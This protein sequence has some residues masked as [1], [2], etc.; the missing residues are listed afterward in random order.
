MI[1]MNEFL[2]LF[3]K[4][5]LLAILTEA[6]WETLKM[7]WQSNKLSVDRAGA[8]FVGILVAVG[9]G[10]DIFKILDITL[11]VPLLGPILT[12]ILFSRGAN[13]FHDL[14][15]RLNTP[16]PTPTYNFVNPVIEP[17]PMIDPAETSG[18]NAGMPNIMN[19]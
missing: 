8:L 10:A 19:Q 3:A 16:E 5:T 6:I 13:Y 2:F 9:A 14:V 18:G 11:A 4:V 12:G 7:T 15:K 1:N 17:V